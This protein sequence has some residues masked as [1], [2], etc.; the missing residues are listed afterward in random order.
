MSTY[1]PSENE[2]LNAQPES[3]K[4]LKLGSNHAA[5]LQ[6]T[7][8]GMYD[9]YKQDLINK[10]NIATAETI[11]KDALAIAQNKGKVVQF[12]TIDDMISKFNAMPSKDYVTKD[13]Q[14]LR[15]GDMINIIQ[16]DERDFW[17]VEVKDTKVT[18]TKQTLIDNKY[19]TTQ[20]G[21]VIV[22]MSDEKIDLSNYYTKDEVNDKLLDAGKVQTV[23]VNGKSALVGSDAKIK[24][25]VGKQDA[26]VTQNA[27]EGVIVT[28]PESSS[29]G[30]A[31]PLESTLTLVSNSSLVSYTYKS[32][33]YKAIKLDASIVVT[34]IYNSKRELIITQPVVVTEN[35]VDYIYYLVDAA[36][37]DNYYYQSVDGNVVGG[38]GGADVNLLKNSYHRNLVKNSL[39][40]SLKGGENLYYLNGYLKEDGI[41]LGH[42]VQ[43]CNDTFLTVAENG[44]LN[45]LVLLTQ[46]ITNSA[47]LTSLDTG[48]VISNK[49]II[50]ELVIVP[51]SSNEAIIM[52]RYRIEGL[53][54]NYS[55]SISGLSS[56][57]VTYTQL[58]SVSLYTDL[59][60]KVD[61]LQET[62]DNYSDGVGDGGIIYQHSLDMVLIGDV[63]IS[64]VTCEIEA[65]CRVNYIHHIG[66][67]TTD[68]SEL[69]TAYPF[70]SDFYPVVSGFVLN[71]NS[72][73]P[74]DNFGVICGFRYYG[75]TFECSFILNNVLYVDQEFTKNVTINRHYAKPIT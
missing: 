72:T 9:L 48:D 33:A 53:S 62:V 51:N 18:N 37:T 71:N 29:S 65:R 16:P 34:G 35:K 4:N 15:S 59:E 24:I 40:I 46:D 30:D 45:H 25:K 11:A 70:T 17:V 57:Y 38:S 52:N 54:G 68:W 44:V 14:N 12:D 60:T 23:T 10:S 39:Y 27:S 7:K 5:H 21:Y 20:F 26:T 1:T 69:S 73:S 63:E 67:E 47:V 3:V 66:N 36:T 22:S 49:S 50:H 42:G 8:D 55:L 2:I 74:T 28:I 75:G 56:I 13:I 31:E 41:N 61:T 43:S 64:G 32:V 6:A 19:L 58:E